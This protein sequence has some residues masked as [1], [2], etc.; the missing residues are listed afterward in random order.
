MPLNHPYT[1]IEESMS[2]SDPMSWDARRDLLEHGFRQIEVN[3]SERFER[4]DLVAYL[5]YEACPPYLVVVRLVRKLGEKVHSL[6][7]LYPHWLDAALELLE[8]RAK[9]GKGRSWNT[10]IRPSLIRSSAF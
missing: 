2:N 3:D 5:D 9:A 1:L 4:G 6:D 7:V 8:E 10:I